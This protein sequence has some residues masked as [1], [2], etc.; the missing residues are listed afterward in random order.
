R[1]QHRAEDVRHGAQLDVGEVGL[2]LV[3]RV[4][5]R[6][7]QAR[8]AAGGADEEGLI[9]R[10]PAGEL[11]ER[12]K[13]FRE[14]LRLEADEVRVLRDANDGVALWLL[15]T[16]QRDALAQRISARPFTAGERLI[17]DRHRHG[18]LAIGIGEVTARTNRNAHGG[19]EVRADHP[20][21]RMAGRGTPRLTAG[22]SVG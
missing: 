10:T 3:E 17:D 16:S 21:D 19:E 22:T 9:A 20:R 11:R 5:D 1:L 4:A 7:D 18:A 6:A 12:D 14:P 2:Q 13:V 15:A 8:R